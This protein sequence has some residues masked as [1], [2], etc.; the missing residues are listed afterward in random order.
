M[1]FISANENLTQ[2]GKDIMYTVKNEQGKWQ[3]PH[4]LGSLVNTRY[5]EEG[6]YL[7]TEG[8]Q[9]W[10]SSRGHNSMGGF[11]IFH[12]VRMD[13]GTWS[14]PENLGYPVNTAD[15]DLFFREPVAGKYGYYTTIREN[16]IGAKDIYKVIF[17]DRKK[18]CCS[19]MRMFWSQVLMIH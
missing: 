15:D 13:D 10:F 17:L 19:A 6:I 18:K 2:G 1:Y 14:D 3:D 12:S 4:D 8:N 11:D 7:S 5:D 16:G 9:L